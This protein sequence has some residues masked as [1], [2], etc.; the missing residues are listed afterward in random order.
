LRISV[1]K[2][3]SSLPGGVG[4]KE[5]DLCLLEPLAGRFFVMSPPC[6]T[7][8]QV[9]ES[10]FLSMDLHDITLAIDVPRSRD[11][12]QHPLKALQTH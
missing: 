5:I 6:R 1:L 4:R 10:F 8:D 11:S 9:Q 2:A 12:V 7:G 3:E